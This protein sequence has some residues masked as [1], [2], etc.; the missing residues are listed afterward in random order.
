MAFLSFL[1]AILIAFSLWQAMQ[2][3]QYSYPAG[4]NISFSLNTAGQ[5]ENKQTLTKTLNDLALKHDT[6]IYKI[7]NG[8]SE[9][10]ET[11]RNLVVFGN[12]QKISDLHITEGKIQWAAPEVSGTLVTYDRLGE[13][14]LSGDYVLKNNPELIRD[15][16]ET[17]AQAGVDVAI[18]N[19]LN[20]L[21]RSASLVAQSGAGAALIATTLATALLMTGYFA[22]KMRGRSIR[23]LGGMTYRQIHRQDIGA[24][25]PP[26]GIG[27]LLGVVFSATGLYSMTNVA[28][29]HALLPFIAGAVLFYL[30]ILF[31]L[32]G[33]ISWVCKP[34][35]QAVRERRENYRKVTLLL[36]L[37]ATFALALTTF[38]TANTLALSKAAYRSLTQAKELEL[39]DDAYAL[40]VNSSYFDNPE[41]S[42]QL[43]LT[44]NTLE[45]QG[46]LYLSLAFSTAFEGMETTS[47]DAFDDIFLVN[48]EYLEATGTT[49]GLEIRELD[50][51]TLQGS[52]I[53]FWKPQ[54][55]ILLK[56]LSTFNQAFSFYTPTEEHMVLGL[57]TNFHYG[58]K[59]IESSDALV[60]LV[61]NPVQYLQVNGALMPLMTTGNVFFANPEE[62]LRIFEAAPFYAQGVY[63]ADSINDNSLTKAQGFWQE[64]VFYLLSGIL[65]VVSLM[66]LVYTRAL[67]WARSQRESIF[68]LRCAGKRYRKIV[69]NPLRI[70]VGYGAGA[71]LLGAVLAISIG[72]YSTAIDGIQSFIL[73]LGLY[74]LLLVSSYIFVTRREFKSAVLRE[75]QS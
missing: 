5:L 21:V 29:L 3:V 24:T 71:L 46:N 2:G 28:T 53:D 66:A 8:Q 25:V 55:E 44:L 65:L 33:G 51:D 43:E 16:Q 75:E 57:G 11:Q 4:S 63:S 68:I 61:H 69:N 54:L 72:S 70:Q 62:T 47:G 52:F 50:Q 56:D 17:L 32:T 13:I 73:M 19:E 49:P 41:N 31:F 22:R 34:T 74:L 35:L 1:A 48:T 14:P 26:L 60:V 18:G 12:P 39:L 20:P 9:T 7:T 10:T 42:D 38:T 30:V 36:V 58:G 67:T 37:L 59:T 64:L 45:A 15:I 23:Y 27:A 40:N 6:N